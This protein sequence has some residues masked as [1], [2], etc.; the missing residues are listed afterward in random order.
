MFNLRTGLFETNSSSEHAISVKF[1]KYYEIEHEIDEDDYEWVL[2]ESD[3]HDLL[4]SLPTEMLRKELKD[5]EE[6]QATL[7]TMPLE[8]LKEELNRRGLNV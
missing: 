2:D 4:R 3:L 1:D 6:F 8:I 7:R 5:R